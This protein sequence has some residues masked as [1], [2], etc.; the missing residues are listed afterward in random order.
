MGNLLLWLGLTVIVA[1]PHVLNVGIP[2][3]ILGAALMIVGCVLLIL[4]R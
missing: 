2:F 4:K 1:L 3:G